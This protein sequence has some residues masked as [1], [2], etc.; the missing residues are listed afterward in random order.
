MDAITMH[1]VKIGTSDGWFVLAWAEGGS[2]RP[3]GFYAYYQDEEGREEDDTL[4]DIA[5]PKKLLDLLSIAQ[6]KGAF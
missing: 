5:D 3:S 1:Q 4:F 2:T 6:K